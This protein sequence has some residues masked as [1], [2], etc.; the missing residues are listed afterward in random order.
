MKKQSIFKKIMKGVGLYIFGIIS[1]MLLEYLFKFHKAL[2]ETNTVGPFAIYFLTIIILPI[3]L[4]VFNPKKKAAIIF[5]GLYFSFAL[6]MPKVYC[7]ISGDVPRSERLNKNSSSSNTDL[8]GTYFIDEGDK[9]V[10]L[11]VGGGKWHCEITI[12]GDNGYV[13]KD[14]DYGYVKDGYLRDRRNHMPIGEVN[15][16]SAEITFYSRPWTLYK[17]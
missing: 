11:V 3:S 12:Q 6:I 15:G 5:F 7:L 13:V 10:K 8:N 9:A 14:E 17:N 4:M 1:I 2:P 16:S